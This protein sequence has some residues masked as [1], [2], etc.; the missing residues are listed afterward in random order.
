MKKVGNL[1]QKMFVSPSRYI[2]GK[3]VLTTGINCI[4]DLG[5]MPY[6]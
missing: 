6:Y 4:K 5:E 2:Q 3:G 1:M